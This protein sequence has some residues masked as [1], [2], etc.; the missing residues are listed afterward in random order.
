MI[1]WTWTDEMI[2]AQLAVCE[3]AHASCA[4]SSK[5][6]YLT[7]AESWLLAHARTGYP[8]AL[9]ELRLL[10][11]ALN[12]LALDLHGGHSERSA[13]RVQL[14]REQAHREVSEESKPGG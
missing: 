4:T 10:R 13:N 14:V 12:I 11:R 3:A 6:C 8:S 5:R 2:D 1:D 7:E 9:R